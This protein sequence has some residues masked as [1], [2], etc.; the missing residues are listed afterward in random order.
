MPIYKYIFNRILTFFQNI[1]LGQ[2]ISEYHSGFRAYKKEFLL[3]ID[4]ENKNKW[5]VKFKMD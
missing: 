5:M 3:Q 1:V 2:K 4:W